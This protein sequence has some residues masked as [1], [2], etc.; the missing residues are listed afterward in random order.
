[1]PREAAQVLGLPD[2]EVSGHTCRATLLPTLPWPAP[3]LSVLVPDL[4][5]APSALHFCL[6]PHS[7]TAQN[8]W[9]VSVFNSSGTRRDIIKLGRGREECKLWSAARRGNCFCCFSQG[10]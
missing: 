5:K 7:A 1:M 10:R 3:S 9:R 4:D 6:L 8:Q 2:R